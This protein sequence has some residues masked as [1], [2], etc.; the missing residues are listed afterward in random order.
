MKKPARDLKK[1][2][3]V[4]I[5]NQT[6]IVESIEIS[7]IGKQGKRKVRIV[8]SAPLKDKVIVIKPEDYFFEV[9]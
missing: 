6:Y 4:L 3:K 2:D 1:E 5:G 7:D 8:A 9:F